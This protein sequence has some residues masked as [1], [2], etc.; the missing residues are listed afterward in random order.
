MV[1]IQIL[2]VAFFVLNFADMTS[3]SFLKTSLIR[4]PIGHWLRVS[5][6]ETLEGIAGRTA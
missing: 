3:S 4:S 6:L 1:T 5:N 2:P